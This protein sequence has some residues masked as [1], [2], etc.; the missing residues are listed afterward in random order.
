MK[1]MLGV[2]GANQ[3]GNY[4]AGRGDGTLGK[5]GADGAHTHK[6]GTTHVERLRPQKAFALFNKERASQTPVQMRWQRRGAPVAATAKRTRPRARHE[7]SDKHKETDGKGRKKKRQS[8]L[9]AEKGT[10]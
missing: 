2:P 5:G 8:N 1:G 4:S 3:R 10:V 6:E 9:A 7:Q